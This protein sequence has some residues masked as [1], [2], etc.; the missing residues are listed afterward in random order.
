[1]GM[2][3][4]IVL[5]LTLVVA[6]PFLVV[7]L[8]RRRD[9]A[10]AGVGATPVAR[11]AAARPHHPFAAVSVRPCA[12]RPCA[13]VLQIQEQRFL[14]LRAPKLPVA[15]CTRKQCGCR[16][17]RHADR[18]VP[19]DRRDNFQRFGALLPKA[20]QDRRARDRRD[21]RESGNSA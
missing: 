4:W 5:G 19:S 21:G 12:D 2:M 3:S 11:A 15:D 7:Q 9:M 16:Y 20:G 8:Q 18:R 13:A 17:V 14:A 10:R 6:S 1:M